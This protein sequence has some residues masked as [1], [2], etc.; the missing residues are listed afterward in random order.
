MT[1][2]TFTDKLL[3]NLPQHMSKDEDSNNYKFLKSFDPSLMDVDT[4]INGLK[5]S[6]QLNTTRGSYLDDIG[7]LFGINRA[8]GES[9]I[10]Y[11]SRIK[12]FFQA[13]LGGGSKPN[14]KD[15]LA[16]SFGVDEEDI[17]IILN[18]EDSAIFHLEVLINQDVPLS[19]FDNALR[20][21]DKTKAAGTFFDTR[22]GLG[23]VV[24]AGQ[25]EIFLTQVGQTNSNMKLL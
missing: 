16:N 4:N 9:N 23:G 2:K 22:Q 18:T 10:N 5:N 17:T 21:V 11:R 3:D 24:V 20:I 15:A 8:T 6:V 1:N 25:Q 12:A 7:R 14:M 13:N 19:V